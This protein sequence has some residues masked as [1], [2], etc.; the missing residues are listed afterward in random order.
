M[1]ITELVKEAKKEVDLN[2][3][4]SFK[5]YF[6][7]I[8]SNKYNLE[9]SDNETTLHYILQEKDLVVALRNLNQ[10]EL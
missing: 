9:K 5:Y 7:E 4:K 3:T 2:P 6:Q 8:Y 1:D 10:S